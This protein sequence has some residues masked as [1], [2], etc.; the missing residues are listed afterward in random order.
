MDWIIEMMEFD[1]KC[2]RCE[3]PMTLRV[4][5]ARARASFEKDGALCQACYKPG[6]HVGSTPHAT[7]LGSSPN[8]RPTASPA[9]SVR[10]ETGSA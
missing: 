7:Q 1:V 6:Y 5:D 9:P 3:K 4:R 8:G 2:R 10:K